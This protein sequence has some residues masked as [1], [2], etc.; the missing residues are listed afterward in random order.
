MGIKKVSHLMKAASWLSD[1]LDPS[2]IRNIKKT[3]KAIKK[4]LETGEFTKVDL[5]KRD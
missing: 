4:S 2:S 3:E 5:E 1:V